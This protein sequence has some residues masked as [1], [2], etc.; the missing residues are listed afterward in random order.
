MLKKLL[1]G[2]NPEEFGGDYSVT[3]WPERALSG[4]RV[5]A[6]PEMEGPV[7]NMDPQAQS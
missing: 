4:L 5:V 6:S 2:C 3:V 7:K 1:G